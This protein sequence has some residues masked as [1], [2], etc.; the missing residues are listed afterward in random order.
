MSLLARIKHDLE[1]ARTSETRNPDLISLLVTLYSESAITGKNKGNR[2]STDEEVVATIKRF[3]KGLEECIVAINS[4]KVTPETTSAF[5]KANFELD[6][7]SE[8]LPKQLT[9]KEVSDAV[10]TLLTGFP[11][12]NL[13]AVMKHFKEN[14]AGLYDG[15]VLSKIVKAKLD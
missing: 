11:N 3:I 13:G 10:E 14:Y 9:E 4:R 8:Y 15:A 6:I 12:S 2:D 1:K 7:L 5:V